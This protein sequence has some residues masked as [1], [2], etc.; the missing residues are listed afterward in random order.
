MRRRA[1]AAFVSRF[2]ASG[3]YFGLA[4]SDS[5]SGKL[6][7]MVH[8]VL[9]SGCYAL[10]I[11]AANMWGVRDALSVLLAVTCGCTVVK[12]ATVYGGLDGAAA[13]A[14]ALMKVLVSCTMSMVM[15][16]AG[17]AFPTSIRSAGV[18]LSVFAAG[19]GALVGVSLSK[20]HFVRKSFVFDIFSVVMTLLSAVLVQWLPEV[21]VGKRSKPQLEAANPEERKVAMQASLAPLEHS[22][23]GRR[24]RQERR[25]RAKTP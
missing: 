20:V 14:H 2:S 1:V 4:I 8:I 5:H 15:C 3:I 12:A 9:S 17:D 11:R 10:L 6:W 7:Q 23:K 25:D 24:R 13:Y 22:R 19:M 18:S 16:Y 21:F